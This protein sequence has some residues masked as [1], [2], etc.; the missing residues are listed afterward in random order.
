MNDSE[1]I[2][3]IDDVVEILEGKIQDFQMY[4]QKIKVDSKDPDYAYKVGQT[5]GLLLAQLCYF[6]YKGIKT[7]SLEKCKPRFPLAYRESR[8]LLHPIP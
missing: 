3:T 5:N 2:T 6:S 1:E 4:L 8:F 7:T